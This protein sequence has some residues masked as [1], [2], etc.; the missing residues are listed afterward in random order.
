MKVVVGSGSQRKIK[1]T[2]IEYA[3]KQ[4]IKSPA[5]FRNL[6]TISGFGL[7]LKDLEFFA[8]RLNRLYKNY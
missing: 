7:F 3:K 8:K 5:H 1:Q 6:E 2:P 4:K